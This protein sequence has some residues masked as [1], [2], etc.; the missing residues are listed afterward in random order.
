MGVPADI[1]SH[2]WLAVRS[3]ATEYTRLFTWRA[4]KTGTANAEAS[5]LGIYEPAD[6]GA[7]VAVYRSQDENRPAL[8]GTGLWFAW[9]LHDRSGHARAG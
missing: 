2:A 7:V 3:C 8:W 1:F 9:K 5:S 6:R 4:V